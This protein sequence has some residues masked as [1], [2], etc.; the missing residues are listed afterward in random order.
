MLSVIVPTFQESQNIEPLLR[1][2]A[3]V[4]AQLAE[5]LEVVI[6]DDASPD[7]TAARA[8]ALFAEDPFGRVIERS[9]PRDLTQAVR[10]GI[11]QARGEL[12]RV[13]DADLSHPPELLPALV[14]AVHRGA[15]V[16]VASRY[17]P[18]GGVANWPA[19]RRLLSRVGNA[20]VRPLVPV[21]DATSG[22]FVCRVEVARALNPGTA[23]FK[24]LLELLA[25]P[26]R[27]RVQEVPYLF[28][29]RRRGSSKLGARVLGRYLTQVSRL[30]RRRLN[31][32]EVA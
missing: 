8:R 18:G 13:M 19:S 26:P 7:G 25:A 5:P 32:R 12:I 20:L 10:E 21:A 23:G 31:H 1:R 17:A 6:V 27:R 9:G 29:D 16:A 14:E 3:R 30:Y 24:I 2:L 15:D 28:T 4:R 22:Y 11:R